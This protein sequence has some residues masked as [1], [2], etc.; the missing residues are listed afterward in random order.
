MEKLRK[1]SD[2]LPTKGRMFYKFM[3]PAV[4]QQVDKVAVDLLNSSPV[5]TELFENGRK[6]KRKLIKPIWKNLK[7]EV[8]K[9]N[10]PLTL[11]KIL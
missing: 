1:L 4:K 6:H 7:K 5:L 3:P 10:L 8:L 2:T 9:R 11:S